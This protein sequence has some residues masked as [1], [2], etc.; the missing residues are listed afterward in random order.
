M[1][2]IQFGGLPAK[3]RGQRGGR[4]NHPRLRSS[5]AKCSGI[6]DGF[7]AQ[8]S[9]FDHLNGPRPP[10]SSQLSR[11]TGRT[12]KSF[13]HKGCCRSSNRGQGRQARE[14]DDDVHRERSAGVGILDRKIMHLIL[15]GL[16]IAIQ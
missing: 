14:V 2:A 16:R 7:T 12:R 9:E 13:G 11:S 15:S 8:T 10:G 6:L 3:V 5:P 4:H 1:R